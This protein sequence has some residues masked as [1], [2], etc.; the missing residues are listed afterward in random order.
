MHLAGAGEASA[1]RGGEGD[2]EPGASRRRG[3]E[4]RGGGADAP[5]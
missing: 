5:A 3:L 4:L 1:G 2:G